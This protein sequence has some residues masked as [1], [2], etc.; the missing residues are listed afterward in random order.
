MAGSVFSISKTI[1]QKQM[2]MRQHAAGWPI[3]QMACAGAG[4]AALCGRRQAGERP[5]DR[6]CAAG[7]AVVREGAETR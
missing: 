5:E 4:G 2:P 1:A 3:G 6:A 7:Q